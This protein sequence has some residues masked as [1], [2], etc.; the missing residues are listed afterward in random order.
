M[1]GLHL[2]DRDFEAAREM[3]TNRLRDHQQWV[4]NGCTHDGPQS[5]YISTID[6]DRLLNNGRDTS[7]LTKGL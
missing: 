2:F 4:E 3:A 5:P 7:A 1:F 6:Y